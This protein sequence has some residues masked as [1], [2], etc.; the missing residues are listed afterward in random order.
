MSFI[1]TRDFLSVKS[2]WI[3]STFVGISGINP[4]Q[5]LD[6]D[7]INISNFLWHVG[8]HTHTLWQGKPL[9]ITPRT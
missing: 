6:G 9:H 3:F 2:M 1:V 4:S 5:S 7:V 8:R